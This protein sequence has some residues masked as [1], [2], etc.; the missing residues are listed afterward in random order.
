[1]QEC[2][3]HLDGLKIV[4]KFCMREHIEDIR[5]VTRKEAAR[6]IAMNIVNSFGK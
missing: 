3:Y 5:Y 2:T 6:R 1:M 4:Y